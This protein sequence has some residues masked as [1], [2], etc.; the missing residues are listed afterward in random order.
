METNMSGGDE[1]QNT[2]LPVESRT[3]HIN[4]IICLNE[5][6]VFG[7]KRFH[8]EKPNFFYKNEM[9]KMYL[10]IRIIWIK[11]LWK[12]FVLKS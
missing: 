12:I 2:H 10:F 6:I 11:Y 3:V 5:T 7:F 8:E 1:C 4:K 9:E